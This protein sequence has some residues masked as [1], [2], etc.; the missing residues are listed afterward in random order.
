MAKKLSTACDALYENVEILKQHLAQKKM[1][2]E[3][4]IGYFHD[5]IRLDMENVRAE[6]DLLEELTDKSY[7]PYPTYSDL[8]YY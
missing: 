4:A 1:G 8:L 7:W 6:A 5:V 2:E 3:E